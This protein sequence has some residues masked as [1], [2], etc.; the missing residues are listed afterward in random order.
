VTKNI[1]TQAQSGDFCE[2][3]ILLQ[4]VLENDY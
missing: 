4:S 1:Q 2:K 3:C